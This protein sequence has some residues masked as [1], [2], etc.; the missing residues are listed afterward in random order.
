MWCN[1][2]LTTLLTYELVKWKMLGAVHKRRPQSG[3]GVLSS[4]ANVLQTREMEGFFKC[5]VC[6]FLC[7]KL[8]IFWNLWCVCTN[9]GEG[10]NFSRFCAYVYSDGSLILELFTT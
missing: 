1:I 8:R 9:K 7:K 6:T 5:I 10:V 4:S 2:S 3:K